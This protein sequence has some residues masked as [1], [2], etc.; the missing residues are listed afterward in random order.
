MSSKFHQ[1]KLIKKK[2]L[3]LNK[4]LCILQKAYISTD[5]H[6]SH[7]VPFFT[8]SLN[9]IKFD[10]GNKTLNK[11]IPD[12]LNRNIKLIYQLLGDND[13]EIY[14]GEWTL[15]SI[16]EAIKIYKDYCENNQKNIFDIGYRY[17]GLGHIEVISCDL[18]SHLL[19]YRPDGGS[20]GYDREYNYKN[21]IEKGSESYK[22]FYFSNWFY[23][24][25][26]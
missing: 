26:L 3:E 4:L 20:N 22:K 23:N 21:V 1:D 14:I 16:N 24:I 17:M 18:N 7:K 8:H 6:I 12:S 13:K 10:L 15:M 9:K 19:F 2:Q 11:D 25:N 5:N